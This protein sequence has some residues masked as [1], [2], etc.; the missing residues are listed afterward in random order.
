MLESQYSDTVCVYVSLAF[1]AIARKPTYKYYMTRVYK[2]AYIKRAATSKSGKARL[3]RDS[4]IIRRKIGNSSNVESVRE[5]RP[6]IRDII[7]LYMVASPL[8]LLVTRVGFMARIR[9]RRSR[10]VGKH[11]EW[12]KKEERRRRGDKVE[13]FLL[14]VNEETA[15]IRVR[16]SSFRNRH[17]PMWFSPT[18]GK[19]APYGRGWLSSSLRHCDDADDDFRVSCTD[20]ARD[21]TTL[22]V[23][24]PFPFKRDIHIVGFLSQ[25]P[26][27]L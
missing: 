23:T 11:Y 8:R 27:E 24:L 15:I 9:C 1:V 3:G 18:S 2:G 10:K 7:N 22:L 21:G 14:R 26:C 25:V 5:K 20:D 16:A 4:T 19:R 6:T 17:V 12:D 13:D